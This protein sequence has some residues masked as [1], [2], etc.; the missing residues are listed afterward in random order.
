MLKDGI[1]STNGKISSTK[2]KTAPIC[3]SLPP[4]IFKKI[5]AESGA[6][7]IS[8]NS[9]IPGMLKLTKPTR[10]IAMQKINDGVL[11]LFNSCFIA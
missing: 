8:E 3:P 1:T 11:V 4:K 5:N 7:I 9:P 2:F 10:S 6:H